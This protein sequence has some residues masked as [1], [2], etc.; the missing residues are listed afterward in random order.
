MVCTAPSTPNFTTATLGRRGLNVTWWPQ[1]GVVYASG[2]TFTVH[3]RRLGIYCDDAHFLLHLPLRR[4]LRHP[5]ADD[6]NSAVY[7]FRVTRA[8]C[9]KSAPM[10]FATT[11]G[12]PT[13]V[14]SFQ[15]NII[16]THRHV[17]LGSGGVM[18]TLPIFGAY[19]FTAV[20]L[21]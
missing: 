15:N 4:S 20:R 10:Q 6:S 8:P 13:A 3:Y 14:R 16:E 9:A 2:T 19:L 17:V 1:D 7:Y 11:N 18:K 21:V 12:R 5:P